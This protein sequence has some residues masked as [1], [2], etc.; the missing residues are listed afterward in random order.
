MEAKLFFI[1]CILCLSACLVFGHIPT[2]PPVSLDTPGCPSNDHLEAIRAQLSEMVSD[3]LA[4]CGGPGWRRVAYLNMSE[5]NTT[6]PDQWRLFQRGSLSLC[7]RKELHSASCDSVHYSTKRI[8]GYQYN[9]PDVALHHFYDGTPGNQ[10]NEPYLDGVSVT[11]GKHRKHIWSFFAAYVP[12][13]CCDKRHLNHT[14]SL[15]FIGGNSFCDS[16]HEGSHPEGNL[17]TE[18]RL[19]GSVSICTPGSG[20]WFYV[21]LSLP[22]IQDI[23]L[24]VCGDE[25]VGNED[26]PLEL[27]EIYVK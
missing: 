25:S 21:N 16:A 2:V 18:H 5:P 26:T 27:V 4:F 19:W 24:R 9:T 10:I 20:P 14:G 23:E 11:Y 1:A 8:I 7:G 13:D 3:T 22:S 12:H 6:C 15:R 17:F